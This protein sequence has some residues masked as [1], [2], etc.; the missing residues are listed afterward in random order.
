[1]QLLHCIALQWQQKKHKTRIIDRFNEVI[2]K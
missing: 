2:G 1:M